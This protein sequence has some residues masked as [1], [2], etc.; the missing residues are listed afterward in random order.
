VFT[1]NMSRRRALSFHGPPCQ[2]FGITAALP[3]LVTLIAT[4]IDEERFEGDFAESKVRS[5]ATS[6]AILMVQPQV[7]WHR[8]NR[9]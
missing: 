5:L 9:E 8:S 1:G 4:F 2:V 6:N 7:L 3:L